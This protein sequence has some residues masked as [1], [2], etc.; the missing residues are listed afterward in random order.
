MAAILGK[1][2]VYLEYLAGIAIENLVLKVNSQIYCVKFSK[3]NVKMLPN[4]Y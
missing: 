1:F 2:I 4:Y 3:K